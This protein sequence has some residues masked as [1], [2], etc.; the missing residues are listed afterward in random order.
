MQCLCNGKSQTAVNEYCPLHNPKQKAHITPGPWVSTHPAISFEIHSGKIHVA[1][2]H[3][4]IS[5]GIS[6]KYIFEDEAEANAQAIA[7]LP[8]L[9]DALQRI[10][11]EPCDHG[12]QGF[13][14][15]ELSQDALRKAGV[16]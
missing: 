5:G 14:P 7:A 16:L 3:A 9:I 8:E 15:R 10:A 4:K 6:D 11:N 2:A 12:P 1:S 13:C